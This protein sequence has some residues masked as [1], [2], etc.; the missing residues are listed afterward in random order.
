MD[1]IFKNP[2]SD[3]VAHFY[4]LSYLEGG[5]R[6]DQGSRLAQGKVIKTPSEPIPGCGGKCLSS[7]L[8]EI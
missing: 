5:D 1:I 8:L 6:V 7:Q 4:N 3:T 2:A